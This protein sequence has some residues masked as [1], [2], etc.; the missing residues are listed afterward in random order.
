M[1]NEHRCNV[2]AVK[3]T[4]IICVG[5]RFVPGD[6]LGCRVFDCL[7]G[8]D[9]SSIDL[10]D[11]GLC[12]IDLLGFIEGRRRVVF[13]D[14]V[15][16]LAPPGTV[17]TLTREAVAAHADRYGHGAGLPWL[18]CMAPQ[19]CALPLPEIAL[20]GAEGVPEEETIRALADRSLEI[21]LHGTPP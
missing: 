13:V 5:N 18:L 15:S 2:D 4:A 14:A 21:A 11:G 10:I 16:S 8:R 7:A 1:A 20:V 17:V 3:A 9:F 6:D 19:V 12:G